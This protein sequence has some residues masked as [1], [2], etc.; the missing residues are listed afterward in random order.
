MPRRVLC[1]PL[2]DL[3]ESLFQSRQDGQTFPKVG[4]ALVMHYVGTLA[5]DGSKFDSSRDKGRPFQFVIG[6]GQVIKGWDEGVM[7]MS[8]G[9]KAVLRISS[10]YGYGAQGAGGVIP[11]NADLIF[12]VR[13]LSL[14]SCLSA[15][16][17]NR[18]THIARP[19]SQRRPS[20]MYKHAF[21]TGGTL[22]HWQPGITAL[23]RWMVCRA[24]RSCNSSCIL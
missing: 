11:P 4:D 10:D 16:C 9:E 22:L 19:L 21:G 7:K 1:G 5:A 14:L 18:N 17:A 6:I 13:L 8:L 20:L 24:M 12:E 2:L 15:A 23:R 3:I